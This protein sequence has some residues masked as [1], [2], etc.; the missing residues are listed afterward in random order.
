[1]SALA[2]VEQAP[3]RRGPERRFAGAWFD[4]IVREA[5]D[6]E[7]PGRPRL[8]WAAAKI[9]CSVEPIY[10][11]AME[12][13]LARPQQR[14]TWSA[15]EE[16]I[17]RRNAHLVAKTIVQRLR[18][19][20]YRRSVA[21]VTAHRALVVGPAAVAREDSGLVSANQLARLLGV[22]SIRVSQWARAG[23]IKGSRVEGAGTHDE[24]R[25]A[26]KDIR[27]FIIDHVG[28]LKLGRIDRFWLIDILCPRRAAAAD[29]A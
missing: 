8:K 16:E 4:S 15:E 2:S 23:Y 17:L 22:G 5:Y 10:M 25:F 20:G 1:M 18:D 14:Q 9:G 13:G 19:A 6:P 7:R 12:L 29:E 11:R 27:R 21:A 26:R 24:W 28:K 3:P